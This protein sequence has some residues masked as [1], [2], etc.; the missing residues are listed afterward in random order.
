MKI[1]SQGAVQVNAATVE[2]SADGIACI[3]VD[4]N[5]KYAAVFGT[6]SGH[7]Q[8]PPTVI[9]GA[10]DRTLYLDPTKSADSLTIVEF[11]DYPGWEV[12]CCSDV[13]R[14]TLSLVLVAPI[15]RAQHSRQNSE[16]PAGRDSGRGS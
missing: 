15:D 6:S 3:S 11:P 8:L 16:A 12:F 7:N 1:R 4:L 5:S 9:L 13:G 2:R 10:D 14:Y